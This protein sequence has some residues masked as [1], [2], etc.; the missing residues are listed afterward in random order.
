MGANDLCGACHTNY[1]KYLR[2]TLD[3]VQVNPT[4]STI[5]LNRQAS[6]NQ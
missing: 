4:L 3:S 2:D 1:E 6:P 5:S